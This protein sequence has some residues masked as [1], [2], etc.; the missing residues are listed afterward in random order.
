M[1]SPAHTDDVW[2]DILKPIWYFRD[3]IGVVHSALVST[4]NKMAV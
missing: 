1:S 3:N 2:H 4:Q